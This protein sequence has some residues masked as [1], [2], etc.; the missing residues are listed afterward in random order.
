MANINKFIPFLLK[1]EG[2][3]VSDPDDSGGPTNKGIT[4]KTWQDCGYDKN[5]DGIIDEEDLKQIFLQDLVECVLR[6]HYWNRWQADRIRNQSNA[7]LLVDWVWASGITGI[8][9]PQRMLN[10]KPDGIAGEKTL[11][12]INNY[13]DQQELFDRFKAERV[14]YIERICIARPANK[15]F[16]KGWLNRLNDIR[17][18]Y[19]L[20][21]FFLAACLSG[22]KSATS[23]KS[24]RME[25]AIAANLEKE[26]EE[27]MKTQW[28][29]F[30]SNQTEL[31]A[32]T[33]TVIETFTVRFDASFPDSI[34]QSITAFPVKEISKTTVRQGKVVHSTAV[35]EGKTARSDS[36]SVRNMEKTGLRK[37]ENLSEKT[38]AT[39]NHSLWIWTF[40]VPVILLLAAGWFFRRKIAG[41]FR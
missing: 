32:N 15:R 24:L 38:A 18:A 21:A 7:N 40:V 19:V 3:Y 23:A 9:T 25:T 28:N 26:S 5:G 20:L 12:A 16:K 11:A 30:F 35:E 1:W 37:T 33:E 29:R 6:P 13:P 27:R 22:C 10:L 41:F 2:G 4:L 17:F 34:L 39:P 14:A 8:T 36:L 31:E